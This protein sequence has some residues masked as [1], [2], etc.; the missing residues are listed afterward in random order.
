M[1][2]CNRKCEFIFAILTTIGGILLQNVDAF[3]SKNAGMLLPRGPK[4]VKSAFALQKPNPVLNTN[5]HLSSSRKIMRNMAE[6]DEGVVE[7]V[8]EE[9]EVLAQKSVSISSNA[10]APFLSQGEISDEALNPDL[11]DPKQ[12][13]V[14]IYIVISLIP[15]LFLIPLM[16][17]SRDLIPLDAL[18]PVEL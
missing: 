12:T 8:D 2:M 5:L 6:T 16:L 15:V 7:L 17:G 4:V 3:T 10:A 11:S 14:I 1:N 9:E 18:P 13:R